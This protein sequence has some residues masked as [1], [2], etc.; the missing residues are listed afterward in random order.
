MAGRLATGMASGM[1]VSMPAEK[2]SKVT[3]NRVRRMAGRQ[4]LRLEGSRL[5]DPYALGYAT[6]RLRDEAGAVVAGTAARG[7]DHGLTLDAV[8]SYLK[9]NR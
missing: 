5:R 1:V 6:Y 7:E 4:R 3:E 8:E 2:P 9:G